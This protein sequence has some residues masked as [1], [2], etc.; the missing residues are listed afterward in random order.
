MSDNDGNN[1]KKWALGA[2]VAGLVGFLAGI[3]TAPKSGKET[4]ED[5][6]KATG[7]AVREVEKQLKSAHT[8]LSELT[9]KASRLLKAGGKEAKKDLDKAQERAKKAQA[10]VKELLS[11]IHEGSADD[12]SLNA[13]LKEAK[14]AKD[15][16]AKF[17]KK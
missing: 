5:I 3:L 2:L 12:P 8:E 14:A 16:L 6:K 10:T 13:A 15:H 7:T 1:G 17:L 9:Q 4:R 11:A